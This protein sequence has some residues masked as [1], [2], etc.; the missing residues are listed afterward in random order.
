M[1]AIS[2]NFALLY[3]LEEDTH[4]SLN[5]DKSVAQRPMTPNHLQKYTEL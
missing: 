3:Y 4:E 2:C 5:E 1:S